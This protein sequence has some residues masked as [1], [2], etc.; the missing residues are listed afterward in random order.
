MAQGLIMTKHAYLKS[1]WNFVDTVVLVFAW[2]EE[3]LN[4]PN[5]KALR[6]GRALKPLR[7]MKRNQSMRV[8]IDA[9]ISTLQPLVY[10]ILFVIFTLSFSV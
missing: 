3:M 2:V 4:G 7:L 8:V 1:G 10:V 9:L 5:Y 6:M